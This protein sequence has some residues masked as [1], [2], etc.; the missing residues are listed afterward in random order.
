MKNQL[1]SHQRKSANSPTEILAEEPNDSKQSDK[2]G[3]KEN[4]DQL[5]EKPAEK[6]K[7]CK[8]SN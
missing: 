7:E 5:N 3:E 6:R 4:I 8:F 2:P 1:N